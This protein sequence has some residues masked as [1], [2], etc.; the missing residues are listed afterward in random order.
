MKEKAR[1]GR[2]CAGLSILTGNWEEEGCR[3]P[4]WNWEEECSI[5]S[6]IIMLQCSIFKTESEIF[7]V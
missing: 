6:Y 4:R 7:S 2:R 3:C 5:D 1:R